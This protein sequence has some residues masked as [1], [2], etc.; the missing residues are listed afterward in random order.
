M[1]SFADWVPD[2]CAN[3]DT[4]WVQ[5]DDYEAKGAMEGLAHL[6]K[7]VTDSAFNKRKL[8]AVG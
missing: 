2:C 6:I 1:S 4:C 7:A 5:A 8:S 3:H